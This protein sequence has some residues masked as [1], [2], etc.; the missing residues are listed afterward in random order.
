MERLSASTPDRNK[1]IFR[2]LS[3]PINIQWELTPWCNE[4]CIQCYNYWRNDESPSKLPIVAEGNV[5]AKVAREIIDNHIFQVTVTGGEPLGVFDKTYP[6]L[7]KLHNN[8]VEMDFNSNLTLFDREKAQ[9]LKK[10]GIH[11]ILTSLMSADPELNDKLANRQNT[12]KDVTRGIKIALE[13]GFRVSVSMVITKKNLSQIQKTAE[14]VKKLGIKSFCVTKA[15]PPMNS[16]NFEEYMLSKEEFKKMLDELIKVK[17]NLGLEINT[18][19]APPLCMLNSEKVNEIFGNKSCSAGRATCTIGFDGSVRP[20]SQAKQVYGKIVSNGDF[21]KAWLAMDPW[22]TNFYIPQ[23]CD[24]CKVVN[25]CRGG[26]RTE[27][28]VINGSLDSPNPYCTYLKTEKRAQ[29]LPDIKAIKGNK[30][31]F[32][33]G[34]R[35]R[36]EDFGGIVYL[37]SNDWLAVDVPLFSFIR[38]NSSTD[39]SAVELA[40]GLNVSPEEALNTIEVMVQRNIIQ[41]KEGD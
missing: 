39:F 18:L 27:A 16:I 32:K 35:F 36:S 21:Y 17:E 14:Y 4:K 26:C 1:E 25:I 22:R 19:V 6:Y 20:C 29:T 7:K 10:I 5:Y 38:T 9:K 24:N 12:F 8:G 33:Q 11:S 23:E 40:K 2:T 31:L 3:A 30:F 13:E 15:S 28:E 41:M 34:I 37:S